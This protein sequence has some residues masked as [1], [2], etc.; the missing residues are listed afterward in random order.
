MSSIRKS[1]TELPW[2]TPGKH[3]FRV[4]VRLVHLVSFALLRLG[5]ADGENSDD[6][7]SSDVYY[8]PTVE[9]DLIPPGAHQ[10]LF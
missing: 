4:H 10:N 7:L 8:L 2:F 6:L 1:D 3:Q 5:R 9:T